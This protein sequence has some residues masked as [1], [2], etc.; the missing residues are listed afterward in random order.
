MKKVKGFIKGVDMFSHPASFRFNDE[1]SYESLCGGVVSVMLVFI[2]VGVFF[3]TIRRTLDKDFIISD[4]VIEQENPISHLEIHIGHNFTFAI[5]LQG[6]DLN[7]GKRWFDIYLQQRHYNS[8]DR[9]KIYHDLVP[10]QRE[11]WVQMD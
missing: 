3:T 4:L 9:L 10:C 7:Q 2:F 1:A 11:Q 6:F 8:S 5:G